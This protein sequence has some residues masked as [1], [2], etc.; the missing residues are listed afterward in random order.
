MSKRAVRAR[1]PSPRSGRIA[2]WRLELSRYCINRVPS[3]Q[4]KP[5]SKLVGETE[6]KL[7]QSSSRLVPHGAV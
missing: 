4:E 2:T 1:S 3:Q 7:E 6:A 5:Q